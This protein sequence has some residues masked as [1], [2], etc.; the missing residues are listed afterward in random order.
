MATRAR[1]EGRCGEVPSVSHPPG[2]RRR[3]T[4][5]DL[6]GGGGPAHDISHPG[7][8]P[9]LRH[10]ADIRGLTYDAQNRTEGNE[11][12]QELVLFAPVLAQ[13]GPIVVGDDG[14]RTSTSRDDPGTGAHPRRRP[15]PRKLPRRRPN[16]LDLLRAKI[17]Q[18]I[19]DDGLVP[20]DPL[21]TELDLIGR[22]D[23]GRSSVR[24]ALKALQA[25]GIVEIRHGFGMYV[26]NMS[27][28]GL[29]DG[30]TFQS[31]IALDG[32]Q[33]DL[34]HLVDI[35][36]VIEHGMLAKL[37]TELPAPDLTAAAAA[38]QQMKHESLVGPIQIDTDRQFHEGLYRSLANPLLGPML[39]AF[40]GVLSD[41]RG[42]Y[43]ES[44]VVPADTVQRHEKIYQA[45]ERGD[46]TQALVAMTE[47]FAGVRSRLKTPMTRPVTT[48]GST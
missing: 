22:L 17:K 15:T 47:H 8:A 14:A 33:Q 32:G 3:F 28:A 20:G 21:P 2:A 16:N 36:E 1:A 35:R 40:W 24:E 42:I 10:R 18:V 27:L 6:Q 45:V 13:G 48:R 9:S 44:D 5:P 38:I 7:T 31:R 26:G 4:T 23:A 11:L 19:V 30:L 34:N 43:A 46:L 39:R 25:V 41:A 12:G 37:L 29:I